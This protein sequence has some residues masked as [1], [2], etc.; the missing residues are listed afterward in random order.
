M[1]I[2]LNNILRRVCSLLVLF[3]VS[4]TM[5]I[6]MDFKV[7]YADPE[8]QTGGAY[9][10]WAR[11]SGQQFDDGEALVFREHITWALKNKG[12]TK[13]EW[14]ELGNLDGNY[15]PIKALDSGEYPAVPVN[16]QYAVNLVNGQY[17]NSVSVGRSELVAHLN[18]RYAGDGP[19]G[20]GSCNTETAIIGGYSQGADVVGWALNSGDLSQAAKNHIGY[21]ALYGDPKFNAGPLWSRIAR[22]NFIIDWWWARGDDPGY[23]MAANTWV[24][25]SSAGILGARSPYVQSEFK[26]RFGSWCASNDVMCVN[27]LGSVSVHS[28][29][30][31]NYWIWKSASEIANAATTK[32]NLLV[33][34]R[35]SASVAPSV[36]SP[37]ESTS[38][39][40]YD[41][42]GNSSP[43]DVN[44][45]GDPFR[46]TAIKR[47]SGNM[48]VFYKDTAGNLIARG[49]S[50]TS[51][52]NY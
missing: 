16:N 24:P 46:P 43:V 18:D 9:V 5:I 41:S 6:F 21:V 51:G 42:N 11:G 28:D 40:V 22:T 19:T 30:Y 20:G 45:P 7:A 36:T 37:P 44:F 32:H 8:C 29:S 2:T 50:V 49:W 34:G 14:A 48:E 12:F 1:M 23:W 3:V 25:V 35:A 10:L 17:N 38:A 27:P 31:Q 52:W 4:L 33:A 15:D 26:G 47:D 39:R 13:V